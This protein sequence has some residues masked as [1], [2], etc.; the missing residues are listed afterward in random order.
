MHSI[1]L[2]NT[3]HLALYY[4]KYRFSCAAVLLIWVRLLNLVRALRA[5]GPLVAI[6]SELIADILRYFVV[7]LVFFVPYMISVWVLFGGDQSVAVAG[8]EDLTVLYRVIVV[9]FRMSLIDNFPYE[10]RTTVL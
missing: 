9:M 2:L 4:L 5:L 1:L 7:Y 8:N 10:V 3:S 6:I